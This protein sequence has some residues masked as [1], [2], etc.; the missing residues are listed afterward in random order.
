MNIVQPPPKVSIETAQ[1]TD[2]TP[3][4]VERHRVNCPY[5]PIGYAMIF[6]EVHGKTTRIEGQYEPRKCESC[7]KFFL[8]K[9]QMKVSGRRL[10]DIHG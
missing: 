4:H 2:S 1:Q 6:V 10:E 9:I 8:L 5:C 3:R 7:G